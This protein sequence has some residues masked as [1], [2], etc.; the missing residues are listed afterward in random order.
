MM[1]A[2]GPYTIPIIVADVSRLATISLSVSY[3]P[4]VLRVRL[5]QEGTFLQQGGATVTFAQQ[6]DDRNGRIDITANRTKDTTGASGA[7]VVAAVVF[8]AIGTGSSPLMTSGIATHPDGSP[9][10]LQFVP[11]T[12]TVK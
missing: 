2:G 11:V 10:P 4:R 7:G 3:N 8:D 6:V 12:V 5:I 1:V 9:L